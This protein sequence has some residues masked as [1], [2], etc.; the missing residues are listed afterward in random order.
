MWTDLWIICLIKSS[1]CHDD[2]IN[3]LGGKNNEKLLHHQMYKENRK[4]FFACFCAF[5]DVIR[6]D[7]VGRRGKNDGGAGRGKLWHDCRGGRGDQEGWH[8]V[9]S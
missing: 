6:S 8:Q 1:V 4:C 2:I 9:V 5:F 7:G 3:I